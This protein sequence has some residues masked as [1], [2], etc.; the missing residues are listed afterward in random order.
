[1]D[2]KILI[3]GDNQNY[4][5]IDTGYTRIAEAMRTVSQQSS[6]R[7]CEEDLLL[8]LK[9]GLNIPGNEFIPYGGMRH[10]EIPFPTGD[11]LI[12]G[13][14]LFLETTKSY[15]DKHGAEYA[16]I[17]DLKFENKVYNQLSGFAQL[18]IK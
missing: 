6:V 14:E 18:L 8:A 12:N 7:G 1:M 4:F 2:V 17:Q 10:L 5:G 9:N 16:Q 15:A 3:M 11:M 13:L